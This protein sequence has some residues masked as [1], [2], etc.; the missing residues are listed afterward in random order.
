MN[1]V[2]IPCVF[3]HA[4]RLVGEVNAVAEVTNLLFKSMF[5]L[6]DQVAG[7][8]LSATEKQRYQINV[9]FG[10]MPIATMLY[11]KIELIQH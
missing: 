2:L 10:G 4:L 11:F 5:R 3:V 6:V 9:F 1:T 7:F 8:V